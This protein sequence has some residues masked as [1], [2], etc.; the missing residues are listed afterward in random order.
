MFGFGKKNIVI[1]S[2][3]NGAVI[4][5][6]ELSDPVFSEDVIG[7]GIA[8]RPD[9][10]YV[11]APAKAVVSQMFDTG[12]AVSLVTDSGVEL[13]IHVGI[14]TVELKGNHY[15]K[16]RNNDESV[17]TGDI[18]I[19]FNVGAISAD[20]YD[21][22]TPIVVCNPH[23]FKDILFAPEGYIRAGDPLITIKT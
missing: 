3:M 15:T 12:H 16:H 19:E 23:E 7:R 20:G 18:L 10:G 2:P 8:I 6:S 21:T 4:S 13:L 22:V 14:D 5:V 17:D 9:S 11:K 1:A